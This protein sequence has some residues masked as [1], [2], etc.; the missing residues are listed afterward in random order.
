[1]TVNGR[2]GV[3]IQPAYKLHVSGNALF[4]GRVTSNTAFYMQCPSGFT[5]V[6]SQGRQLGCMQTAE[7]NSGNKLDWRAANNYCF[8]NYGGILPNVAEWYISMANFV[9]TD[10]IDDYEW[11]RGEMDYRDLYKLVGSGSLTAQ[12]WDWGTNSGVF[13]CWIP[14]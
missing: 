5:S 2:L 7:A 9:L 10:E 6:E 12:T 11:T 1:L 4:T 13:R 14:N 8:T 3:G